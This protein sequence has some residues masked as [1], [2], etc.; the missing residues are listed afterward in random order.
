MVLTDHQIA[1]W[2]EQGLLE[3]YD[4]NCI[5]NIGYDLRAEYFVSGDKKVPNVSLKHGESAFVA[6]T[7]NIRLPN[8][9]LGR[10]VLKNSRLRQGLSMDA[11]VYQP[12]HHTKV[13]FRVTNVSGNEIDLQMGGKYVT[14]LFETL[15]RPVEHPY[16]GTFSEE[17]DYS[18]LGKYKDL[19]QKEIREIEKKTENLKDME[20]SIYANVLVILTVFVALFSFLSTNISLLS[21]NADEGRFLVYNF[22]M[23]GCIS[24]LVALLNG[25]ISFAKKRWIP[26]VASISSFAAAALIFFFL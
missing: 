9:M 8:D 26:W 25:V 5:T 24:F 1:D 15:S 23:L 12:G 11:P 6:T 19:Y 21:A 3:N 14:I 20:R 17:M 22:V 13:F 2:A 4:P 18:G 7:E 16:A 10:I